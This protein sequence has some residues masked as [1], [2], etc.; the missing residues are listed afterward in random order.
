MS[1]NTWITKLQLEVIEEENGGCCI[2]I[3]WD[4]TDPD[5]AEWTGWGE[6]LQRDFVLN[7]LQTAID[8]AFSHVT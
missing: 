4:D 6:Q 1:N 7:A 5:L 8:G 2:H 3:E